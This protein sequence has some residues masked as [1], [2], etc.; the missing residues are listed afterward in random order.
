M[1]SIYN[2][3]PYFSD[4]PVMGVNHQQAKAYL[5]WKT[6]EN[7][8]GLKAR[9]KRPK[10]KYS[11]PS[12]DELKEVESVIDTKNRSLI[13][14]DENFDNWEI[15]NVDYK[16]FVNYI[17]DSIAR[18]IL[19]EEVDEERFL[20][21]VNE[22]EE[23]LEPPIIKWNEPINWNGKEERK[24]LRQMFLPQNESNNRS[25]IIDK[26]KLN[27]RYYWI[28]YKEAARRENIVQGMRDRSVFIKRDVIN[29]YPDT[30]VWI[31]QGGRKYAPQ[32]AI[33][34][35]YNIHKD[36]THNTGIN[37]PQAR[38]YYL[39]KI[40]TSKN[41]GDADENPIGNYIIPAEEEWNN[42][43]TGNKIGSVKMEIPYPSEKFS[44]VIRTLSK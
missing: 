38:A 19:G 11:F 12:T 21:T 6:I 30:I 13:F 16:S 24:A 27:F 5:H 23:E 36:N 2:W 34:D 8:K 20:N 25:K 3:H 15:T 10:I 44:Y 43:V 9:K 4:Y 26:R 40:N 18:R 14:K 37:Y 39:W 7:Q 35:I 32:L 1:T 41:K 17:R 28:D 29:V 31:M 42:L 33:V 22:Y